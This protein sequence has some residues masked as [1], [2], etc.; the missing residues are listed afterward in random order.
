V[1]TGELRTGTLAGLE[2]GRFAGESAGTAAGV[3]IGA[4]QRVL[5]ALALAPTAANLDDALYLRAPN[6]TR[7]RSSPPAST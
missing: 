2:S 7:P 3:E 4:E 5:A 1:A 6:I